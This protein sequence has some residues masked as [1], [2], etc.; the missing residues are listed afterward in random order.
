MK[1]VTFLDTLVC[2]LTLITAAKLILLN[3]LEKNTA[4]F[5]YKTLTNFDFTIIVRQWK[6]NNIVSYGFKSSIFKRVLS[7]LF[8]LFIFKFL[9]DLSLTSLPQKGKIIELNQEQSV[10]RLASAYQTAWNKGSTQTQTM[11]I[12]RPIRLSCLAFEPEID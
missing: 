1:K 2:G 9:C 6:F 12:N 3:M 10:N 7:H 4:V 11:M 5:P 8:I